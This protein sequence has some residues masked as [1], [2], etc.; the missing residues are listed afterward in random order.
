MIPGMANSALRRSAAVVVLLALSVL[1]GRAVVIRDDVP[2]AESIAL[3]ARYPA[4]G[5]FSDSV[6][7]TLIRPRWALTAAHVVEEQQPFADYYVTFAGRHYEVEK[8]ILHPRRVEGAVDSSA[9]LALLKLDRDVEGVEPI[10]LYTQQNEADLL[11]TRVGWGMTGTGKTG[12]TGERSRVPRG[13][14][15]RIEAIFQDSFI[16]TF[17]APPAG[18]KLEGATGLGDSG[19]PA[20]VEI[21]GKTYLAGVGSFATGS[22][23]EGTLGKYGT[24]NAYCRVSTHVAWINRTIAAD[25]P[26][27]VPWSAL[28]RTTKSWPKSAAGVWLKSYYGLFNSGDAAR[29]AGFSISQRKPKPGAP[30]DPDKLTATLRSLIDTYGAYELYG[31]K[32]AGP[33]RMAALVYSPKAKQWRSLNLELERTA[34]HRTKDFFMADENAP[35]GSTARPGRD[36]LK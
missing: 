24:V 18:T 15:N 29:L 7:C 31:Y 20:F 35:K 1:P 16:T 3:G 22:A 9:D 17:D 23:E 6:A 4:A 28:V 36:M 12:A 19:G 21:A 30:P 2:E 34:P 8:I 27:T 32:T 26:A 10:P 5:H 14:T 33:Y 11:I 25:P 13:F